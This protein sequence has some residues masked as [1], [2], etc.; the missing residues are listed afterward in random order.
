MCVYIYYVYT[1]CVCIYI[2]YVY[3]Y[4][5]IYVYDIGCS[6]RDKHI[7]VSDG[8]AL[9]ELVFSAPSRWYLFFL[10]MAVHC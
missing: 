5:C 1:Y 10:V 7:D 3:I 6:V 8:G 4:V 9:L 2:Y